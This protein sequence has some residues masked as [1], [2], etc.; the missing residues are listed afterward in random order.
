MATFADL[1]LTP[2]QCAAV[3]L[4]GRFRFASSARWMELVEEADQIAREA[5][6]GK[7]SA[8]DAVSFNVDDRTL[9]RLHCVMV[10]IQERDGLTGSSALTVEGIILAC[11]KA[12]TA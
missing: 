3:W 5:V 12:I 2:S 1:F 4:Y 11:E 8:D 7:R 10:D 9:D 6:D